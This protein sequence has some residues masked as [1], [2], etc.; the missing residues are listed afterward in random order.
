MPLILTRLN[1]AQAERHLP[2]ESSLPA[3]VGFVR[4]DAHP[5]AE[6]LPLGPATIARRVAQP[7]QQALE[8]NP[9]RTELQEA[10]GG[11]QDLSQE[12][13][14]SPEAQTHTPM[15]SG[16]LDTEESSRSNGWLT[17]QHASR[18]GVWLI[19]YLSA[20][21]SA[22]RASFQ[23]SSM[24]DFF[25][26]SPFFLWCFAGVHALTAQAAAQLQMQSKQLKV[27]QNHQGPDATDQRW[28][29]S[30]AATVQA[31]HACALL[32]SRQATPGVPVQ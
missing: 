1:I 32:Q 17:T 7:L 25:R 23:G 18:W 6:P 14:G 12:R 26:L 8:A 2:H 11:V 15:S 4:P 27:S 22:D 28:H 24:L 16:D 31:K 19:Y 30:C 20:G 9:G 5:S 29:T 3:A 10:A 21:Q 13:V